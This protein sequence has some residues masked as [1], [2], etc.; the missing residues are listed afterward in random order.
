MGRARG[1]TLVELMIAVAIVGILAVVAGPA[2]T[3]YVRR[4]RTVEATMNVRKLYDGLTSYYEAQHAGPQGQILPKLFPVAQAWTP[5]QGACCPKRCAPDVAQWST[6]T[7]EAL[8]FEVDDPHYY[9]YQADVGL[10]DGSNPGDFQKLQA[11]GDLNCD[12]VFSLF[13]R[14]AVVGQFEIVGGSAGLWVSS[15]IE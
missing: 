1:F 14:R 4:A 6:P 3:K 15:D 2:F 5:A 9:S 12:G 13:E 11:S 10:G 7:W 8:A